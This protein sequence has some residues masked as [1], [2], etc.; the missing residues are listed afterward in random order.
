MRTRKFWDWASKHTGWA[1]R[2]GS[3]YLH[4]AVDGLALT[5]E[6]DVLD[7]GCGPGIYFSVLHPAVGP[8]GTITGV[9]FS[10][11][12]L[13]AAQRRITENGWS[14]I[15]L[16]EADATK[17]PLGVDR[18]DAAIAAHSLSAMP[19]IEAAVNNIYRALKPGGRLFVTDVRPKGVLRLAYRL[20][21]GAP[22]EDVAHYVRQRFDAVDL[23]DARGRKTEHPAA[24]TAQYFMLAATKA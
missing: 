18:F 10:P 7:L 1:E 11:R 6:E 8:T 4:L 22:G 13:A 21:A 2:K 12:M 15:T 23:L 9:D 20:F 5:G 16:V 19:D 17:T 24:S 3:P 14:N